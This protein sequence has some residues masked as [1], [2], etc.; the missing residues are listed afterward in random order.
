MTT[1]RL[2]RVR[3]SLV[4][5]ALL[6]GVPSVLALG[7]EASP[8]EREVR[9]RTVEVSIENDDMR[10]VVDGERIPP[11]R[12]R[13]E[14]HGIVVLDADGHPMEDVMIAVPGMAAGRMH[15][16]GLHGD[17]QAERN[18]MVFVGPDGQVQRLDGGL[19]DIEWNAT[20]PRV[21]LGIRM[22]NAEKGVRVID[23][24]P[25]TPAAKAGLRSGDVILTA[26]DGVL[27]TERLAAKL[28]GFKPG[29]TVG[30]WVLRGDEKVQL[31]VE[32]AAW[33]P[34]LAGSPMAIESEEMAFELGGDLPVE[35]RG[36]IQRLLTNRD[37]EM[38]IRIEVDDDDDHHDRKDHWDHEDHEDHGHHGEFDGII[39]ALMPHL[40]AMHREFEERWPHIEREIE[41]R[42]QD[43]AREVESQFRSMHENGER[44]GRGVEDV[45]RRRAEEGEQF[46]RRIG[47]ALRRSEE[48]RRM[49]EERVARL[50]A[51]LERMTREA[52]RPPRE[53]APPE[54]PPAPPDRPRR[55]G[56]RG[57]GAAPTSDA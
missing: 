24:L 43:F 28:Q 6:A 18:V 57:D 51:M 38:E 49:L 11:D 25:G 31:Q 52:G 35:I 39:D 2:H 36:L 37:G 17:G 45:L 14:P 16:P 3:T 13:R 26:D 27:T 8:P 32:L 47:E 48:Q 12:L 5:A 29:Q 55:R 42:M 21:M 4:A 54:D 50:E 44:F 22:E 19:K 7:S 53:A 20:P 40:D 15:I 1:D 9:S 34:A 23:V 56:G 33:N 10:V 41:H 30:M 46:A